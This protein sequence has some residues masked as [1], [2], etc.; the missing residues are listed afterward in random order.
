MYYLQN[1]YYDPEMGRFINADTF[2]TT[3]QG[4][5][6]NNMFAYCNNNPVNLMDSTGT[7]P[8]GARPMQVAICDGGCGSVDSPYY[9]NDPSRPN[10]TEVQYFIDMESMKRILDGNKI[11][12][13]KD[14]LVINMP[15]MDTSA[16]SYGIIF[17][18]YNINFDDLGIATLKH[19]YGHYIQYSEL[20]FVDYGTKIVGPS[21]EGF[22]SGIPYEE[23]YSQPWEYLA[24]LFGGVERNGYIYASDAQENALIYW[25][26][27]T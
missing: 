16:F 19:E 10:A 18:G 4:L 5:L 24:D 9:W 20:G 11:G 15:L 6:G 27:I 1:R 2:V 13:Y 26:S 21:L 8:F 7:L 14:T 3:G 25:D 12:K 22:W 17:I 23:Y